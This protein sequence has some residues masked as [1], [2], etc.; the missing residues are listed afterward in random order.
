M[1]EAALLSDDK[2]IHMTELSNDMTKTRHETYQGPFES[3]PRCA[4]AAVGFVSLRQ[5]RIA[6]YTLT[7]DIWLKVKEVLLGSLA[8]L[9]LLC[10]GQIL[11]GIEALLRVRVG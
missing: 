10:I 1:I 2:C 3:E 8:A 9:V 4:R 11:L 6:S 5:S 7:I